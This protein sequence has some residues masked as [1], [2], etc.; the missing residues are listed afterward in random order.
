MQHGQLITQQC[1]TRVQWFDARLL[2]AS[3]KWWRFAGLFHLAASHS[4]SILFITQVNK[5]MGFT[6]KKKS[7]FSSPQCQSSTLWFLLLNVRCS[8]NVQKNNAIKSGSGKPWLLALWAAETERLCWDKGCF[9][10]PFY[11]CIFKSILRLQITLF[12]LTLISHTCS[13]DEGMPKYAYYSNHKQMFLL[14]EQWVWQWETLCTPRYVCHTQEF[15]H[16]HLFLYF[17]Y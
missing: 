14:G 13:S 15:I 4:A 12:G 5:V 7:K 1:S 2:Q 10:T 6:Q 9:K 3:S 16:A 8:W 17:P 11:K